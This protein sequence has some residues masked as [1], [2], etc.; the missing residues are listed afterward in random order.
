LN[1]LKIRLCPELKNLI[2]ICNHSLNML[3]AA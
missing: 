3:S 2:K 1:E